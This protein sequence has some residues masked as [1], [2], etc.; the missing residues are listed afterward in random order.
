MFTVAVAEVVN[1]PE[2]SPERGEKC[3]ELDVACRPGTTDQYELVRA[4]WDSV[5]GFLGAEGDLCCT[6]TAGALDGDGVPPW[7]EHD[8]IAG[9]LPEAVDGAGERDG[10]RLILD[11]DRDASHAVLVGPVNERDVFSETN[12]TI[13]EVEV[14][15]GGGARGCSVGCIGRCCLLC[16][17]R[18]DGRAEGGEKQECDE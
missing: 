13:S 2:G 7:V 6:S 5:Q 8:G 9:D 17:R 16:R 1:G 12:R 4:E 11:D 18:G 3:S 15:V 10:N 14:T